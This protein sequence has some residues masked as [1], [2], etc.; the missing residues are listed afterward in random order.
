MLKSKLQITNSY[1]NN[2]LQLRL[3]FNNISKLCISNFSLEVTFK[4]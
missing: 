2:Y 3:I 4:I 1:V